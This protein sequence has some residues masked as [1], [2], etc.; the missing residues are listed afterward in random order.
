MLVQH[1]IVHTGL[2]LAEVLER[3][4]SNLVLPAVHILKIGQLQHIDLLALHQ[5]SL[6]RSLIDDTEIDLGQGDLVGVPILLVLLQGHVV[7]QHTVTDVERAIINVQGIIVGPVAARGLSCIDQVLADGVEADHANLFNKGGVRGGQGSL[8][9]Q[10]IH[11]LHS[12]IF[13]LAAVLAVILRAHDA[14]S[15][16]CVAESQVGVD[17]TQPAVHI[18]LGGHGLVIA[19]DHALTQVERIGQAVVGD[20]VALAARVLDHI[21]TVLIGKGAEQALLHSGQHFKLV[22]IADIV[23]INEAQIGIGQVQHLLCCQ[24]RG[25]RCSGCCRRG[26]GATGR[27]AAC[28]QDACCCNSGRACAD[29]LEEAAT[30]DGMFGSHGVFSFL[31]S[32]GLYWTLTVIFDPH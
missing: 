25:S 6:G 29:S 16:E 20:I 15:Q 12:H 5:L 14:V 31:Q 23:D 13:Q 27:A 4:V 3:T 18:V 32:S 8:E 19:P 10:V 7:F 26:C 30:A 28:G 1:Q 24:L 2:V 22:G 9:S 17:Q 21:H 11:Q